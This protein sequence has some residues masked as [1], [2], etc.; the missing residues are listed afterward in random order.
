M[1]SSRTWIEAEFGSSGGVYEAAAAERYW[2]AA[3]QVD[4]LLKQFRGEQR[5]E[6]SPVQLWPHHFDWAM[7][8][9][10]G[11]TVPGVDANDAGAADEQMAFGFSTGDE[12]IAEPYFY[13]TAYPFPDQLP[14]AALPEDAVWHSEGFSGAVL[15][16]ATLV[17]AQNPAQKLLAYWRETLAAGQ[18]L[19]DAGDPEGS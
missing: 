14:N 5:R 17:D 18:R 4:M 2:Q 6:T 13:V 8:W 1:A 7:S 10:S 11:R 16:Y 9:F 19:M 3:R 15:A 12:T